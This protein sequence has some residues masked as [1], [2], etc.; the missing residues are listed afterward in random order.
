MDS[1]IY[2][3]QLIERGAVT[4]NPIYKYLQYLNTERVSTYFRG[5]N[6]WI[7]ASATSQKNSKNFPFCSFT[8]QHFFT[9]HNKIF[10]LLVWQPRY[11]LKVRLLQNW[12]TSNCIPLLTAWISRN[13]CS[14]LQTPESPALSHRVHWSDWLKSAF[15]GSWIKQIASEKWVC[16]HPPRSV[17]GHLVS[18][19]YLDISTRV[20]VERTTEL[21]LS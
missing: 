4:D 13:L 8:L 19:Y 18:R 16:L 15:N 7:A 3:L 6:C 9:N 2:N 17:S 10:Y 1:G 20:V 11:H 5:S 12:C 14:S 21:P